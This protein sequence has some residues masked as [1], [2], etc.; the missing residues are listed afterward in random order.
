METYTIELIYNREPGLLTRKM[1][2]RW[3]F[4]ISSEIYF[5]HGT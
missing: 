5:S 4:V 2:G 1:F 3:A